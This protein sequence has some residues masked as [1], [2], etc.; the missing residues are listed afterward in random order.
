MD[1]N[2]SPYHQSEFFDVITDSMVVL[3]LELR[4]QWANR[5]AGESVGEDPKVTLHGV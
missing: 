3:D 1:F 5:A 4:I 2:L